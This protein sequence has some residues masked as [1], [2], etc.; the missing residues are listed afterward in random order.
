MTPGVFAMTVDHRLLGPV[1]TWVDEHPVDLGYAQQ[2]FVFAVLLVHLNQVVSLAQLI[3]RV[4]GG[5]Q[6]RSARPALYAHIA[7][8]RRVLVLVPGTRLAK[9]PGGYLLEADPDT[10]D[11]HRFR[12]LV[13]AARAADGG[14]TEDGGRADDLFDQALG[15]WRG[16][17]FTDLVSPW[18]DTMRDSIEAERVGA[19]LDRNEV[20]LRAG[21]HRE[22]TSGLAELC[23]AHP[24][25]E[26]LADQLMRALYRSGRQAAALSCYHQLRRRLTDELG[27]DP[28]PGLKELFE[29]ILR[30]DPALTPAEPHRVTGARPTR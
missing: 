13:A 28:Q 7:R 26:G 11:L 20:Y 25:D 3:D 12:R 8:L 6:P 30:N 5:N 18:M 29:Q 21:R 22:L 10:V 16:V 14:H 4:W 9:R 23:A 1:E 24:L 19:I 17:P 2:R 27:V 15:L